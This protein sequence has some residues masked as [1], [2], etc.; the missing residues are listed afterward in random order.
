MERQIDCCDKCFKCGAV[1]NNSLFCAPC[2]EA[3]QVRIAM[4]ETNIE[5]SEG[6][7]NYDAA[8]GVILAEDLYF[9]PEPAVRGIK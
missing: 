6:L 9:G 1:I 4:A 3:M 7:I 8:D 5:G 2:G